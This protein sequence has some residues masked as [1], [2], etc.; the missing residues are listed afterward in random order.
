MV[1]GRGR[2]DCHS[3]STATVNPNRQD[4]PTSTEMRF[5]RVLIH[6]RTNLYDGSVREVDS[7]GI[8]AT[9]ISHIGDAGFNQLL[10]LVGSFSG[11]LDGSL[12]LV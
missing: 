9:Y 3:Y 10:G 1:T 12:C 4:L 2:L 5:Q 11:F 7:R 6:F 8:G